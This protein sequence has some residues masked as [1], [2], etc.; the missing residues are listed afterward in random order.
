MCGF[1]LTDTSSTAIPRL[2][3]WPWDRFWRCT[4]ESGTQE[5]RRDLRDRVDAGSRTWGDESMKHGEIY[6]PGRAQRAAV[7]RRR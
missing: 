2:R 6:R 3:L 7:Q 4:L 5:S 1:V